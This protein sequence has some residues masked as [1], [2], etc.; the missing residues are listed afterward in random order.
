MEG[1]LESSFC[2]RGRR[3]CDCLAVQ[4]FLSDCGVTRSDVQVEP[5]IFRR[6]EK[7]LAAYISF[8]AFLAEISDHT[9][10]QFKSCV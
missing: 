6:S 9:Q 5:L 2:F 1:G 4:A 8:P 3:Q 10:K 7:S